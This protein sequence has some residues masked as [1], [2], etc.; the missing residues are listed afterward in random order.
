MISKWTPALGKN[1]YLRP[2]TSDDAIWHHVFDEEFEHP[3]VPPSWMPEPHTVL[4]LGAY[5]GLTAAHYRVLWPEARIVAVEMDLGNANLA[6]LNS[7]VTVENSAV[8]F[9]DNGARCYGIEDNVQAGYRLSPLGNR[10]ANCT[11]LLNILADYFGDDDVDFCKMDIEGTEQELIEN[12]SWW[13]GGIKHLLVECH[14]WLAGYSWEHAAQDLEKVGYN[15]TL[16]NSTRQAV[17]A[18]R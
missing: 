10:M 16:H 4:D 9:I 5:I 3:H 6:R 8:V 12:A 13:A 2:L 1:V 15:T 18:W 11:P 14:D 17:F 7:D